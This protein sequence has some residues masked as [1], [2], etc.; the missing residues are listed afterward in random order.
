[1][2][3][4]KVSAIF[5]KM[6]SSLSPKPAN[7]NFYLAPPGLMDLIVSTCFMSL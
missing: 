5:L 2:A 3:Y 6:R 4:L 7:L 1:M